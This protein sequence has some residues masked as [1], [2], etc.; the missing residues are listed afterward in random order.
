MFTIVCREQ[1]VSSKVA[2]FFQRTNDGFLEPLI[3]A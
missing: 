3:V 2:D 1:A